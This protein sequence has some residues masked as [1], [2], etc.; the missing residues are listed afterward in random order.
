MDTPPRYLRTAQAA[1]YLC[2]SKS[3]LEQD[4]HYG[5]AKLPFT[6]VGSVVIYDRLDL[7]A[8]IAGRKVTNTCL[9]DALDTK[10]GS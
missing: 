10:A 9:A 7:D 5:K 6:R 3:F 4:R 8:W 1:L 2:V